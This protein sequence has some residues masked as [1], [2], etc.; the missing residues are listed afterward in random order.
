MG[1]QRET[2]VTL[3]PGE[4]PRNPFAKEAGEAPGLVWSGMANGKSL[5]PIGVRNP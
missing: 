2:S 4:E 3:T 5:G 1:V